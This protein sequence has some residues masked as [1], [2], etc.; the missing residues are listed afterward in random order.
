M[1][2][3]VAG[4]TDAIQNGHNIIEKLNSELAQN[5]CKS[6]DNYESFTIALEFNAFP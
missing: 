2:T 5:V 1:G 6:S 3:A 4:S